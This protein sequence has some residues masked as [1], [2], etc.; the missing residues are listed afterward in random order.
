[1]KKILWLFLFVPLFCRGEGMVLSGVFVPGTLEVQG[2]MLIVNDTKTDKIHLF[3][4]EGGKSIVLG[5]IGEGPGEWTHV[6][7][8][9]PQ[10]D[11]LI[12][13]CEN[14]ILAFDY[15][16]H[17][18]RESRVPSG[19]S[20][21]VKTD[22]GWYATSMEMQQDN[23]LVSVLCHYDWDFKTKKKIEQRIRLSPLAGE[24]EVIEHCWRIEAFLGGVLWADTTRGFFY[25]RFSADGQALGTIVREGMP[26]IAMNERWKN[27]KLDEMKRTPAIA[28]NWDLLK[29]RLRFPDHFPAFNDYAVSQ[30]GQVLVRS[31]E[32]SETTNTFW[33][34]EDI[35]SGQWREIRLTA[36]IAWFDAG[37][38][39]HFA[40]DSDTVYYLIEEESGDFILQRKRLRDRS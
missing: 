5:Q 1:M 38:G 12:V 27:K 11:E 26:R 19:L 15:Q 22:Q 23:R 16:G 32:Q 9:F 34:I 40:L 37:T 36:G 33:L 39:R 6:L 20:D 2:K 21:L 14:K 3:S 8:M 25:S 24:I 29:D 17:L 4:L 18:T 31:Y 13:F 7:R 28:E 35:A 30:T 10:K